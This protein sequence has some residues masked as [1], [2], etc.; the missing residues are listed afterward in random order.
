MPV[1]LIEISPAKAKEDTLIS[2][3]VGETERKDESSFD[4]T[5]TAVYLKTNDGDPQVAVAW[6]GVI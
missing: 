6:K 4:P 2:P 5:S 1:T 3:E